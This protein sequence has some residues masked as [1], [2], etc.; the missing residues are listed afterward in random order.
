MCYFILLT[1]DLSSNTNHFIVNAKRKCEKHNV[2][3]YSVTCYINKSKQK[4]FQLHISLE[5]KEQP[6]S[7]FQLFP[8]VLD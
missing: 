5:R 1:L 2:A 4:R 3:A 8:D 6:S 7:D